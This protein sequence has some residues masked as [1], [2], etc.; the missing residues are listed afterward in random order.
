MWF[1]LH[2]AQLILDSLA[3]SHHA[4]APCAGWLAATNMS[5][6]AELKLIVKV[7]VVVQVYVELGI[8]KPKKDCSAGKKKRLCLQILKVTKVWP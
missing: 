5:Q 6:L 1:V 7:I 4:C 2:F 8:G 3:P